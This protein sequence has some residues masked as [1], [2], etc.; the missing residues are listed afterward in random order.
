MLYFCG[1][2]KPS[3]V[4]CPAHG[5]RRLAVRGGITGEGV[6]HWKP[7]VFECQT[8]ALSASLLHEGLQGDRQVRGTVVVRRTLYC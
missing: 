3:E 2:I 6:Q 4:V 7:G 5:D 1:I 8:L